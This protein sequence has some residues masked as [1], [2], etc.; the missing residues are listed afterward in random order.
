MPETTLLHRNQSLLD[1]AEKLSQ[2]LERIKIALS[3]A[4]SN[5]FLQQAQAQEPPTV[6]NHT[7]TFASTNSSTSTLN[8]SPNNLHKTEIYPDHFSA[9]AG[10]KK[11]TSSHHQTHDITYDVT[12]VSRLEEEEENLDQILQHHSESHAPS[13]SDQNMMEI[14]LSNITRERVLSPTGSTGQEHRV[15]PPY[16]P[17]LSPTSANDKNLQ[18]RLSEVSN[19]NVI[20]RYKKSLAGETMEATGNSLLSSTISSNSE[21]SDFQNK[22]G[23]VHSN[24]EGQL[25]LSKLGSTLGSKFITSKEMSIDDILAPVGDSKTKNQ[26]NLAKIED[27]EDQNDF[28]SETSSESTTQEI[29]PKKNNTSDEGFTIKD[30]SQATS[31]SVSI[32]SW[33]SPDKKPSPTHPPGSTFQIK[34]GKSSMTSS[35]SSFLQSSTVNTQNSKPASLDLNTKNKI[36]EELEKSE[37]ED[38]QYE[39]QLQ[40]EKKKI[41]LASG[42]STR[43]VQDPQDNLLDSS[44]DED[45]LIDLIKNVK[46][47]TNGNPQN[48]NKNFNINF[49]AEVESEK[50]ETVSLNSTLTDSEFEP[51][52]MYKM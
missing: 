13:N 47:K 18:K 38:A 8:P 42:S 35:S 31:S 34:S 32:L 29:N 43:K 25:G 6:T 12:E 1:E 22:V 39:S 45:S 17:I 40:A 44:S 14:P 30:Q 41:I 16:A 7:V 33:L 46:S 23:G 50:S 21:D 9:H 28:L 19:T 10:H 15:V 26:Q 37:I 51:V 3:Q 49:E 2:D 24:S 48:N 36:L 11:T 4:K 20:E 27:P 5:L 52:P